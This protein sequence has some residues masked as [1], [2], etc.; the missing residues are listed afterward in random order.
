MNKKI[1]LKS[2]TLISCLYLTMVMSVFADSNNNQENGMNVVHVNRIELSDN[3]EAL[4][5]WIKHYHIIGKKWVNNHLTS[6]SQINEKW[7][8]QTL[9][10]NMKKNIIRLIKPGM[11]VTMEF[12]PQRI[13]VEIN[14]NQQ[15]VKIY[16]G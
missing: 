11:M 14:D 4:K 3:N 9:P 7:M 5:S 13:N 15:I 10:A 2:I 16:I 8:R 12:S 6:Y 1:V